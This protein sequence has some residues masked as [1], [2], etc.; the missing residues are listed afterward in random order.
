MGL[1][2]VSCRRSGYGYLSDML[3]EALESE[4]LKIQVK[5]KGKG[6][7]VEAGWREK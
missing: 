6:S 4:K 5:R 3:W 7:I 1:S 2:A